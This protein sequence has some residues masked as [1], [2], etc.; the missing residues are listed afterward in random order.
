MLG[1]TYS[2]SNQLGG[3]LRGPGD[4]GLTDFGLRA[5]TRMNR[6][7]MAID[8]SHCGDVTAMQTCR[9]STRAGVPV[10]LGRA[11]VVPG[12]EAEGATICCGRSPIPA[13]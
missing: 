9:A 7:G 5:V 1:V 10:A 12:D 6:L 13:A 8:V 2:E 11:G 4:G 3:G